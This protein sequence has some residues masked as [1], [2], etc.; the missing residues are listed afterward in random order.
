MCREKVR[1]PA[2]SWFAAAAL[3]GDATA[4]DEAFCTSLREL[5]AAPPP[6]RPLA[7]PEFVPPWP[8]F[9]FVLDASDLESSWPAL[10]FDGAMLEGGAFRSS[11][12]SQKFRRSL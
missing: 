9:S 3:F 8:A 6:R 1:T 7:M 2:G 4:A 10:G 5:V 12:L 11:R